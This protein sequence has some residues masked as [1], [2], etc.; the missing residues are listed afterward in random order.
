MNQNFYRTSLKEINDEDKQYKLNMDILSSLKPLHGKVVNLNSENFLQKKEDDNKSNSITLDNFSTSNSI[1]K[2]TK[3][4]L[5]KNISPND[6][7][8]KKNYSTN[9]IF[10]PISQYSN[11]GNQFIN[12]Y[13]YNSDNIISNSNLFLENQNIINPYLAINSFYTI[14][15]FYPLINQNLLLNSSMPNFYESLTQKIITPIHILNNDETN[16]DNKPNLKEDNILLNKKRKIEK[17]TIVKKDD[18]IKKNNLKNINN[19]NN[20]Q[21]FVTKKEKE[22]K[23]SQI[24]S[25]LSRKKMFSVYKKSK[26]IF[27][28]R[29]PRNKKVLNLKKKEINCEHKGCE[30]IFRT[31][32]QLI[33]HHYKFSEECHNDTI[34]LLKMISNAKKILLKK[35]KNGANQDY[36]SFEKYSLLYKETMNNISLNEYM[37]VIAGLNFED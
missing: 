9:S 20:D 15:S 8:L 7:Y 32:K 10:K 19:K 6:I 33:Y 28:K 4:I 29:K 37:D 1:P 25:K 36:N 27:K 5:S 3:E 12:Y 22:N 16:H 24:L 34:N 14:N 11:F 31:K 2:I 26:Y 21:L 30:A 18:V 13:N 17:E 23:I 35:E